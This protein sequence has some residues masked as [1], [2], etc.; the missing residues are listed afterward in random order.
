MKKVT[1]SKQ[2]GSTQLPA[3]L[4]HSRPVVDSHSSEQRI[5]L[6]RFSLLFLSRWSHS[7]L[8]FQT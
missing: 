5:H 6:I 4:V 2:E 7:L 8:P 1:D 3:R